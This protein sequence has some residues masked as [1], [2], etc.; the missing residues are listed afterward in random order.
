MDEEESLEPTVELPTVE[1]LSVELLSV[2]ALSVAAE[3]KGLVVGRFV[4]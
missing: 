2:A 3:A 4:F 1:L